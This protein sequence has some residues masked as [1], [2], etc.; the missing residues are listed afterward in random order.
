MQFNCPACN[1]L[2]EIE[3]SQAGTSLACPACN[4]VIRVPRVPMVLRKGGVVVQ[5]PAGKR[6]VPLAPGARQHRKGS[7]ADCMLKRKTGPLSPMPPPAVQDEEPMF[8]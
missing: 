3:N 7:L 5:Q 4:G 6:L 2:L 1:Q 8:L